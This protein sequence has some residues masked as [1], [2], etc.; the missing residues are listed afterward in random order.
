MAF[1][2]I[3]IEDSRIYKYTNHIKDIKQLRKDNAILK[4][5]QVMV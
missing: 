4:P 5:D 1:N 3:N 2:L